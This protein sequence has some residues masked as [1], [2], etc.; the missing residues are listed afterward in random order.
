M[1]KLL[2]IAVAAVAI[3][4]AAFADTPHYREHVTWIGVGGPGYPG[5]LLFQTQEQGGVYG[6]DNWAGRDVSAP[7]YTGAAKLFVIGVSSSSLYKDTSGA[8]LT[9]LVTS[10][11]SNLTLTVNFDD[12][13]PNSGYIYPECSSGANV[14]AASKVGQ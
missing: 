3:S 8:L 6:V 1:F 14:N 13:G 10:R 11:Y 7:G 9:F 2:A 12:R 5:C 4:T